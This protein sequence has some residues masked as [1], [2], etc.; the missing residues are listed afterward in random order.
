MYNV[1]MWCVRVTLV[2]MKTTM[3]SVCIVEL[4]VTV[5]NI[6]ILSVAQ[7]HVYGHLMPPATIKRT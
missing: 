7:Q 4:Q 5:S 6:K 3:R 2:T 1:T